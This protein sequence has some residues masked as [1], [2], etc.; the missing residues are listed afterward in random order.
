MPD[1]LIENIGLLATPRGTRAKRGNEMRDVELIP[2]AIIAIDGGKIIYA[3][4]SEPSVKNQ[5]FKTHLNAHYS[6]VT[7]G[8]I[9]CHTHLIF[10]GWRQHEFSRKLDGASYLEILASGGGILSTVDATRA[11]TQKELEEKALPVINEMI[12][13]GIVCVEAKS[14][15]GLNSETELKQLRALNVLR[16]QTPLELVSTFLGA[17]AVP[18]EFAG[19][20]SDY[21]NYVAGEMLRDIANEDLAEFCDVFCETG[22]FTAEEAEIILN[23]AKRVSMKPK[24]HTDEIARIGG[25]DVAARVGAV[26]AEHLL[27]SEKSDWDALARRNVIGALLPGTSFYLNKPYAD[28]R[29]M[30]EA[31]MALAVASDFNPGSCPC[32]NLHFAMN[33]ACL[34]LGLRPKEALCAVTLNAAAALNREDRLGTLEPGKDASLVIWD[35]PDLDYI[36]YRVGTNL[37]NTV[38]IKGVT[39]YGDNN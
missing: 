18:R 27:V 36:F 34:R 14:G 3:G 9:D 8:L 32:S 38:L 25:C 28:A 4:A 33:L 26:S 20:R 23:S 29:G 7:P 2:D 6:L 1:L 35:A 12:S 15:Y 5:C 11:V 24:L 19:R 13:H 31:G 39:V 37:V 17:H 22:V 16:S 10:G 21:V 30:L